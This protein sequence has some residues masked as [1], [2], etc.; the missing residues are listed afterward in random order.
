MFAQRKNLP[1]GPAR[2]WGDTAVA[3]G[4]LWRQAPV[5]Q[6][7]AVPGGRAAKAEPAE[8]T[9]WYDEVPDEELA[10]E[11][12][13]VRRERAGEPALPPPPGP[14]RIYKHRPGDYALT[15]K[16]PDPRNLEHYPG[17]ENMTMA[18]RRTFFD[19]TYAGPGCPI[20]MLSPES[21]AEY[22]AQQAADAAERKE[23]GQ[24]EAPPGT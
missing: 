1:A 22:A 2:D 6:A 4:A 16:G 21:Q 12:E 7:E 14:R 19:Y 23:Y 9:R 15:W 11:N 20:S 8:I 18:E 10:V 3:L 24:P 17:W 13:R 5:R